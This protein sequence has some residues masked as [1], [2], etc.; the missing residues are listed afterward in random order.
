MAEKKKVSILGCGW[1]GFP[2][3][4]ALVQKGYDVKGST[5]SEDKIESLKQEGIQPYQFSLNLETLPNGLKE[6]L[7]AEVVIITLP[8]KA[9]NNSSPVLPDILKNLQPWIEQSAI[10]ELILISSTSV[11][12]KSNSIV[13]ENTDPA[14][15]RKNG[16]ALVEAENIVKALSGISTTIL[17]LGGLIGYDRIPHKFLGFT[18]TPTNPNGQLNLVHRDDIIAIMQKLMAS[19]IT[20]EVFNIVADEHPKRRT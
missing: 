6:F 1:L 20:N 19:G 12:P 4:T 13:D 3:G 11:Y 14:P 9:K 8:P 10:Q 17:R 7:E 18:V 15:S 2:L 16:H 5:T